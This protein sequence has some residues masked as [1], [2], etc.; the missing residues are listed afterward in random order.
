MMPS[1]S[2]LLLRVAAAW[3][4][5]GL[6]LLA[7]AEGPTPALADYSLHTAL[8]VTV[9]LPTG[10]RWSAV[11]TVEEITR[12]DAPKRALLLDF[13]AA[14]GPVLPPETEIWLADYPGQLGAESPR[15]AGPRQPFGRQV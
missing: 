10:A 14:S 12:A 5:P 1:A 15:L 4:L 8:A 13:G 9:V 2:L 6:G 3:P 11:A 7:L